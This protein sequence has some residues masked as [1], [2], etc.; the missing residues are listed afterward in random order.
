MNILRI[1]FNTILHRDNISKVKQMLCTNECK[2]FIFP[3]EKTQRYTEFEKIY[4]F[5]SLCISLFSS[6][7]YQTKPACFIEA[8]SKKY[9]F[10][11]CVILFCT[12]NLPIYAQTDSIHTELEAVSI[13][14]KSISKPFSVAEYSLGTRLVEADSATLAQLQNNS[15]AE[16]ISRNTAIF[17]KE[18]GNGMMSSISLRGTA[19][20]HTAVSWNGLNINPLT[21]GQVDFSLLPLFF[22]EKIAVH[23]GGESA[24][25]GNGSIG[26]GIALG[27][28]TK[29]IRRWTGLAQLSGGSYGYWFTGAKVQGG[30]ER[31][32][33]RTAILY[34]RSD[35]DFDIYQNT[36]SGIKTEK[37]QNAAFRN[38][39]FTQDFYFKLNKNNELSLN[40]W[41][42]NNYREIQPSIQNNRDTASY[43]DILNRSFKAMAAYKY[44]GCLKWD[45][46]IAYTNDYQL[47]QSDV[48]ATNNLIANSTAEKAWRRLSLKSGASYQ[49]IVPQVYAYASGITDWRANFQLLT[50]YLFTNSF[51]ADI[52]LQQSLAKDIRVPFTPSAGLSWRAFRTFANELT[53]R[54]NA[55]RS[56]KVPTLN[57]RYWGGLD[58]RYLEPED[59]TNTELGLNYLFRSKKYKADVNASGYYN[60]VKNWIMWMPRGDIWKP[61]NIDL[62][63]ARGIEAYLKQELL[64]DKCSFSLILNYAYTKTTIMETQKSLEAL[65]NRQMPLL[66]EHTANVAFQ[67]DYKKI[68]LNITSN[69]VGERT[70]SDIFDVMQAYIVTNA[71]VGYYLPIK[72]QRIAVSLQINNIFDQQYETVPFKAMPERNYCGTVKWIF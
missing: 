51:S 12:I 8:L 71:A 60:R 61:Q 70:T 5:L 13:A 55:S 59:G 46:Y 65:E 57:D 35:N 16:Y 17:I 37:Q 56:F 67:F 6:N 30:T 48:I 62:V 39:G 18:S 7:A 66:P 41:Y 63:A 43:D 40:T 24:L 9:S 33:S 25:Y 68:Y 53:L 10:F 26:G 58:N 34:N 31:W 38:Y 29:F 32:Q 27:S 22:F 19:S 72:T 28:D 64:L 44:A 20:S 3:L 42:T 4:D 50:K 21:M 2:A 15:L 14:E 52:N 1:L 23:P 49:Y 36:F 11:L 45:S 69:F 47:N 54:A